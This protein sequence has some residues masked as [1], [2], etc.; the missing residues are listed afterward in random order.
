MKKDNDILHNWVKMYR[1]GELGSVELDYISGFHLKIY[2]HLGFIGDYKSDTDWGWLFSPMWAGIDNTLGG[3][4]A[5]VNLLLDNCQWTPYHNGNNRCINSNVNLPST[6]VT[7]FNV[8]MNLFDYTVWQETTN[9]VRV[10]KKNTVESGS[11]Q[12]DKLAKKL[13]N[14][15]LSYSVCCTFLIIMVFWY[16]HGVDVSYIWVAAIAF[17]TGVIHGFIHKLCSGDE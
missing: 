4:R 2:T 13:I 10:V 12:Y 14:L 11:R 3:F 6:L 16:V 1:V 9:A 7:K 5:R 17:S 15:T 8:F